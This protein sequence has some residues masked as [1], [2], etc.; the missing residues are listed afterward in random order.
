[1]QKKEK[2]RDREGYQNMSKNQI[3]NSIMQRQV[4]ENA[5]QCQKQKTKQLKTR[6][7]FKLKKKTKQLKTI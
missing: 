1:M 6:Y 5:Y 7:L 4:L 2:D 3:I